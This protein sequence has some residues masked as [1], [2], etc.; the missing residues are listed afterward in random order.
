MIESIIQYYFYYHIQVTPTSHLATSKNSHEKLMTRHETIVLLSG[1]L[2][3]RGR[4]NHAHLRDLLP[5]SQRETPQR[6]GP[7]LFKVF[8]GIGRIEAFLPLLEIAT[9][10]NVVGRKGRGLGQGLVTREGDPR[11][12]PFGFIVL[13]KAERHLRETG[14]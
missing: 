7:R 13:K 4:D 1:N 10:Q 9:N 12:G 11:V 8:R 6:S 2:K 14:R 3:R 5:R